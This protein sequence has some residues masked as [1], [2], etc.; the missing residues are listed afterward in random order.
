L[1]ALLALLFAFGAPADAAFDK[2]VGSTIWA[3]GG[4]VGGCAGCHNGTPPNSGSGNLVAANDPSQIQSASSTGGAGCP[5]M[6]D[7]SSFP[8]TWINTGAASPAPNGLSPAQNQIDVAYYIADYVTPSTTN[9][10]G[11]TFSVAYGGNAT[12]DLT[13]YVSGPTAAMGGNAG[14]PGGNATSVSVTGATHGTI[15]ALTVTNT[16]TAYQ[17]TF[18]YQ[19]NTGAANSNVNETLNFTVSNGTGTSNS[20]TVTIHLGAAP[21]PTASN[22]TVNG[23][24]YQSTGNVIDLTADVTNAQS[25]NLNN[26]SLGTLNY[27]GG[28]SFT[29][30]APTD[31]LGPDSITYTATGV[32]GTTASRT[33][34][35]NITNP[36]APVAGG[37]L[38]AIAQFNSGTP[39]TSSQITVSGSFTGPVNS[40]SLGTAPSH[41][42]FS[43]GP[44]GK[45]NYTPTAGYNGSDSFTVF[46]TNAAGTSSALTVNVTVPA[47]S[48]P[49]A[50]TPLAATATYNVSGGPTTTTTI[51]VAA[52]FTGYV[53]SIAVGSPNTAH[54]TVSVGGPGPET[55]QYTP[56]AGYSGADSFT[57]TA[58]N[59]GGTSAPPLTVNVNV[60]LPGVPTAAPGTFPVAYVT[61]T[62]I[63]LTPEIGGVINFTPP[64]PQAITIVTAPAH[65][66]IN[67]VS[68]KVVTYTPAN[69]FYG[70]NDTFTYKVTG[71]GGTS[72]TATVT[73][74]VGLP[75]APTAAPKAVNVIYNTPDHIDLSGSVTGVSMSIAVATAPTHGT[76][77]I[78]GYTLTYTPTTGYL[79]PDSLTYTTTGPG[80]TS[81]PAT[82]TITVVA[83]PTVAPP[84]SIK[85]NLNSPTTINLANYITGSG[86]TGVQITAPPVHGGATTSGTTVTYTPTLNFFGQDSFS[87][88][89]FGV[90]GTATGVITI[91]VVGRPDPTRD[92]D[93]VGIVD[94]QVS[95]ARR[96]TRVQIGNFQE[97]MESLHRRGAPNTGEEDATD[98]SAPP[99][100]TSR[101]APTLAVPASGLASGNGAA[102]DT[103]AGAPAS[104]VATLGSTPAAAPSNSFAAPLAAGAGARGY[105]APISVDPFAQSGSLAGPSASGL[106][107][108]SGASGAGRAPTGMVAAGPGAVVDSNAAAWT[109]AAATPLAPG[110]GA[111]NGIDLSSVTNG[112]LTSQTG[113]MSVWV[114][115]IVNFGTRDVPGQTPGSH[116][117]TDGVSF[118]ADRRIDQSLVVGV[119]VGYARDR[120]AV[121]TDGTQ[122]SADGTVAAIYASYQP[123]DHTFIDSVAGFGNLNFGSRRF[124]AP[125]DA[126]A[127]GSRSGEQAFL[128]ITAGYD[129]RTGAIHVSP[130]ARLDLAYDKLDEYSES[131]AAQYD[132]RFASQNVPTEDLAFGLKIDDEHKTSFGSVVP[133]F[134]F[135]YQHDFEGETNANISYSNL[136]GGTS[137]SLTPSSINHNAVLSGVGTDFLFAHGLTFGVDY[138]VIRAAGAE[139]S[140]ALRFR[141]SQ[142]LDAGFLPLPFL[143]N[144]AFTKPVGFVVDGGYTSDDNVTRNSGADKLADQSYSLDVSKSQWLPISDNTRLQ[145]GGFIGG[146]EFHSYTELNHLDAGLRSEFQ[147]RP[148]G[149]FGTPTFAVFARFFDQDYNSWERRGYRYTVGTSVREDLTDRVS[150]FGA[151]SYDDREARSAVFTNRDLA[152]RANL[153]YSLSSSSTI[154]LGGEYR[155]GDIVSTGAASLENLD[156]AKVFIVDDAFPGSR[157]AYRFRG[158]T[159]ISTLGY[160]L[161]VGERD[162]LDLSWRLVRSDASNQPSFPGAAAI[163]YYDN[164]VSLVYLVRF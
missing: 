151:L 77:S 55:V 1:F 28:L 15:S 24:T 111:I 60:P 30:N 29:Y 33:I 142:Q 95:E 154:Y 57:V 140:Q 146:E 59:A 117:D 64:S 152:A 104:V 83:L 36:G 84:V 32:G 137:Y 110:L 18:H 116:F 4:G 105:N 75:P 126:T 102:S 71:P 26:P 69:L 43:L 39:V 8:Y 51:N 85:V 56:N 113:A 81:A 147:Y 158:N 108:A 87:Y 14:F 119:G 72:G 164:Q 150:L 156:A 115:G 88:K 149:E 161:A 159:Y 103:S 31:S 68:G 42:S 138:Q 37:P 50:V 5:G 98:S 94:A 48:P 49:V 58:T 99:A 118:G 100:A 11:G 70:A 125:I 78:S 155:Y 124:V 120:T 52:N 144:W 131:G 25:L 73:L 91:T 128:S 62:A 21:A 12:F 67:S 107:S 45:I 2:S 123:S 130:Y 47:P 135:E 162:S 6:C 23:I 35:I 38:A 139:N 3:T 76:T 74:Q 46:A 112:M 109:P 148:S 20:S 132:L 129:Y 86:I 61:Q 10:P 17:V 16:N 19:A 13:P 163:R 66:T 134:R 22:V 7:T 34:T 106:A 157:I 93:V 96:F 153:D 27:G 145:V 133:H 92:P 53:V 80:G 65:G 82:L 136:F 9:V 127:T 101:L 63:D 41:G 40:Y 54:G 114:A 141:L 97:H 79:G 44:I 90:G 89:A 121:G 143:P 122:S 160:N